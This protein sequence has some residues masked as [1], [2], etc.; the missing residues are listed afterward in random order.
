MMRMAKHWKRLP[1]EALEYSSLEIFKDRLGRNYVHIV[2]HAA[3]LTCVLDQCFLLLICDFFFPSIF[4]W[5][6]N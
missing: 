3:T 6:Y 5:I 2:D 1:E 4:S